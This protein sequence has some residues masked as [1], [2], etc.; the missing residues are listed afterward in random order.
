MTGKAMHEQV[1]G[2]DPE[3]CDDFPFDFAEVLSKRGGATITDVAFSISPAGPEVLDSN[4]D[5]TSAV[6]RI[7]GFT[8]GVTYTVTC[9]AEAG[10]LV[11]SRSTVVKCVKR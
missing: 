5:T 1:Y 10:T 7:H 2:I 8:E 6:A 11:L 9:R 3:D 4:N